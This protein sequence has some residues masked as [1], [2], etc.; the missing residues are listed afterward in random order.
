MRLVLEG[1]EEAIKLADKAATTEPEKKENE[2]EC[3]SSD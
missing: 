3:K 1:T 2:H